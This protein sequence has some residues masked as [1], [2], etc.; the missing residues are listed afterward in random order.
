MVMNKTAPLWTLSYK[1]IFIFATNI[2]PMIPEQKK[3]YN[4]TLMPV[5]ASL[6]ILVL[7]KP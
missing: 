1:R 4:Y 2:K 5:H 7:A 6:D 3:K